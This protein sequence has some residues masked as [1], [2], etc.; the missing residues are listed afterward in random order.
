MDAAIPP[1][2]LENLGRLAG[3]ETCRRGVS[4]FEERAVLDIRRNGR[5][6]ECRVANDQAGFVL[7]RITFGVHQLSS[8]CTCNL[9][10]RFCEH[11]VASL[12]QLSRDVPGSTDVLTV[13]GFR[14]EEQQGDGAWST[15]WEAG[16]ESP[17]SDRSADQR[18]R[19]DL[20]RSGATGAGV[21]LR[22]PERL[23]VMSTRW[24]SANVAVQLKYRNRVYSAANVKRLVESGHA[25]G[26]MQLDEFTAQQQQ[27]LRFLARQTEW[28][29][30]LF[31]LSAYDLADLFHCLISFPSVYVRDARLVV[32]GERLEPVLVSEVT[33]D[34][35]VLRPQL[36]LHERGCLP[37]GRLTYITGRA[38]YW[39]GLGHEYWWLPGVLTPSWLRLFVKGKPMRLMQDEFED[40][41][42]RCARGIIPAAIVRADDTP[43]VVGR[44]GRCRP[45]LSLDWR[46]TMVEATLE[47]DYDGHSVRMADPH[48]LWQGSH[49]IA[50]D[51]I[52]EH[53]AVEQ[54]AG[55]GFKARPKRIGRFQ[56]RGAKRLW[57]FVT[58]HL[59]EISG[60][61]Q[62][63]WSSE[64]LD[65]RA[66][67]GAV[68]LSVMPKR[69]AAN[70]FELECHLRAPNGALL[71]WDSLLNAARQGRSCLHTEDGAVMGI[72]DELRQV[73]LL[74][75]RR[76]T[77]SRDNTVRFGAYS[78]LAIS[79]AVAPYL[80]PGRLRKWLQLRERL[81]K[82]RSASPVRLPPGLRKRL[83]DYQMDGVLWL[84]L[85]ERCG[86]HGILAD[87][88]GLGKT[89]QALAYI[90][91]RRLACPDAK[92]ALV[93]CPTSLVENW[94]VDA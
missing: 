15:A 81:T 17:D 50:R 90:A 73:M 19:A 22:I 77:S 40:V 83:R 25:S 26:G 65:R 53:G 70:W 66:E 13:P 72:P 31:Q 74:L 87:E 34:D 64:F 92:P 57:Q 10:R 58:S 18:D 41:A 5:S 33:A 76:A 55:F 49:F 63:Y 35:T 21:R 43:A 51:D 24:H 91:A 29:G 93:V 16:D 56:L 54:L 75:A 85:L 28:H 47:F 45:V 1:I 68:T 82:P 2:L 79:D 14:P 59:D 52:A 32:H 46:K 80:V 8:Q 23:T 4:L 61:W 78:A 6:L 11:A 37:P 69:E 88:M 9:P 38:G 3:Q 30:N 12:L 20:L 36:R 62:V 48:L 71:S 67:S 7:T 94:L 86:V 44:K 27:V 42:D 39:V 60:D 84:N 89:I